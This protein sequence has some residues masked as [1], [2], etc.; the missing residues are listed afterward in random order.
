MRKVLIVTH[1]LLA[2]LPASFL[3][4]RNLRVRTAE[5][6][7]EAARL[8]EAWRPDLVIAGTACVGARN[9]APGT[10]L[11]LVGDGAPP[12]PEVCDVWV[13]APVGGDVAA[14]LSRVSELLDLPTR[15]APRLPVDFMAEIS[16][17]SG[18]WLARI[19]SL[20]E[21]GLLLD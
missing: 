12:T 10:R 16:T 14:L 11:L 20:S 7:E 3:D 4:R 17:D 1:E 6:A 13:P 21:T 19:V 5:T 15:T 18:R 8:A 9:I 2:G